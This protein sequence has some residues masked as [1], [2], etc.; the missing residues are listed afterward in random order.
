MR[1][2]LVPLLALV[3]T[4]GGSP[5]LAQTST[6]CGSSIVVRRADTLSSIAERC[7]VS[8][9]DI[10]RANPRI[11]GSADL[12]AGQELRLPE[13]GSPSAST[14][15]RLGSAAREAGDALADIARDF[16]SSVED[17][18]R[19][20]PDLHERLRRL[21]GELDIP[22]LDVSKAQVSVT[23]EEGAT[24]T[25]VTVSAVGLPKN[26]PVRIGLGAPRSAYEIVAD[27]RTS[28]DG[29]LQVNVEIPDW[30]GEEDRVVFV[31][32][33]RERNWNVRSEPFR[34]TGMK[35]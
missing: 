1:Q 4:L 16:G 33:G 25:P 11:R 2:R 18:L 34:I 29:T 8:E 17:L 28:A 22:S 26:V 10:L 7:N 27:A 23:P 3:L 20:N 15:E 35:L 14:A 24:G 30:A 12:V 19:K 32:E 13:E 5:A 9:L 21:G 6:E 31:V